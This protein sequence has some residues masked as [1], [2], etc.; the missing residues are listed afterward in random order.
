MGPVIAWGTLA[1]AAFAGRSADSKVGAGDGQPPPGY[2]MVWSDEFNG[3]ALDTN[4]WDHWLIGP[5]RDSINTADAVTVSNGTLTITTYTDADRHYTGMISTEGK[6]EPIYGYFE[7]R[8]DFDDSPGRWTAFWMQT[9]T[10][11]RPMGKPDKAGVEIDIVE[12]RSVDKQGG[13]IDGQAMAN[14]HWDGYGRN[15]KQRGSPMF[16]S[17]LGKGF[18]IYALAWTPDAMK[19][20]VDQEQVWAVTNPVSRTREFLILSSEVDAS[21]WAGKPP[22]EGYGSRESSRTRM[23]VD[24]VRVYQRDPSP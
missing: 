20:Y 24:Y 6:F 7:A 2:K 4:K 21:A 10:M 12:H 3:T 13:N 5:R 19:F 17:N 18:H 16:G 9:P 8:I 11:G 22:E 14:L 15:H 1:F 23:V